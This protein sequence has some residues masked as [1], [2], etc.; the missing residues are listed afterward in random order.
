[1]FGGARNSQ[2]KHFL[3]EIPFAGIACLAALDFLSSLFSI[4]IRNIDHK[5]ESKYKTFPKNYC[6]R[7]T[8]FSNQLVEPSVDSAERA[9]GP[10]LQ[11]GRRKQS[12]E[13]R[14]WRSGGP[15]FNPLPFFAWAENFTAISTNI[16]LLLVKAI[17]H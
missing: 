5:G 6:I 16:V 9:V 10:A 11:K 2:Q 14:K 13:T 1:M 3:L 8:Q 12:V 7:L 17:T 4:Q 15:K